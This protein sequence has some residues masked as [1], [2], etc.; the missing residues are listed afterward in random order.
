MDP[1]GGGGGGGGQGPMILTV[2]EFGVLKD[3][4]L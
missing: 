4:C 1:G 2:V 3:M